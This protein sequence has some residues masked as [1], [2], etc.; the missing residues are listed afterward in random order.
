MALPSAGCAPRFVALCRALD[1][2][3]Q[4]SVAIDRSKFK[5]VNNRDMN[6]T[7]ARWTGA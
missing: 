7:R 3:T 6:F 1:L 2:L 4:A 5:A